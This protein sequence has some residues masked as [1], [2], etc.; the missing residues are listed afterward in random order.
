[1]KK[2]IALM[3]ALVIVFTSASCLAKENPDPVYVIGDLVIS[4]PLSICA[5]VIGTAIFIVAL[6]TAVISQSTKQT[7]EAL[8]KEPFDYA[9]TRDLGEFDPDSY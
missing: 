2:I 4:R 3:L 1:M 9:F 6:P 5:F 7:A 8:V